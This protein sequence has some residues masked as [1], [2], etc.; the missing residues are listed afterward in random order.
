M[1][2]G[3][4]KSRHSF[5]DESLG[6]FVTYLCEPRPWTNKI[7]AIS[8]NAK[9]YDLHFILNRAILLKWKYDP[10]TNGL[11][12]IC[13][14]MEELVILEACPTSRVHCASYPRLSV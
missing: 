5:W 1:S 10:I 8:H 12:I 6:D 2:L 4:G 13:M 11:K 14:K 7:V 9:V 3:C